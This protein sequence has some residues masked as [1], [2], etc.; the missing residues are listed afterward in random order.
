MSWKVTEGDAENKRKL[1]GWFRNEDRKDPEPRGNGGK[2]EA[3]LQV[4]LD[5][6][7]LVKIRHGV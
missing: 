4:V 3:S 2:E 5:A 1:S 6:Q 7:Q